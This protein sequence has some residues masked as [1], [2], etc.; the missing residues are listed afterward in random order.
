MPAWSLDGKSLAFDLRGRVNEIWLVK[1]KDLPRRPPLT[2]QLPSPATREDG[3]GALD[4][5]SQNLGGI[6]WHR[7]ATNITLQVVKADSQETAGENGKAANAV[8]GQPGTF[9]HTQWLG[10]SPS[11][12]HEIVIELI[13]ASNI[14]GFTYLPRQDGGINGMIKDYE[15]FVSNDG[16][17]FGAPVANGTFARDKAMKVV[18]FAAKS[19]RYI[20]LNALSEVNDQPWTSAAEIDVIAGP[21]K[22]N[23]ETVSAKDA[24]GMTSLHMAAAAGQKDAVQQLLASGADVKAK[25]NDG[26]TPLHWA[27]YNGHKD[28][29]EL[30][31]ADQAPVNARGRDGYTPLHWAAAKGFEAIA[32]LLLNHQA[33]INVQNNQGETPLQLARSRNH[34]DLAELLRQHG[35]QE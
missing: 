5:V 21:T 30:L 33:D 17:H 12:P 15:L 1:T 29:V 18:T 31:L 7:S 11:H 13:P 2:K 25:A 34:L 35:G 28:V 20:K 8:D 14:T 4:E 32:E 24:N 22:P 16:Q 23:L 6:G 3:R 9:W 27:V 10:D 19:C 26:A